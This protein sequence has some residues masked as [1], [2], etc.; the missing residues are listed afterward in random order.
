MLLPLKAAKRSN[1]KKHAKLETMTLS[2]YIY[3]FL[4]Y[5][6]LHFLVIFLLPPWKSTRQATRITVSSSSRSQR[7]SLDK[8]V[9][10]VNG[11][12]KKVVRFYQK[13]D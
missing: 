12:V 10:S 2:I 3:I 13:N 4:W 7:S 1:L 6:R 8:L 5:V 9:T 11:L